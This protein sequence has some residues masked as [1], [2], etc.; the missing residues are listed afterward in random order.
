MRSR[1]RRKDRTMKDLGEIEA[2]LGRMAVG[3]LGLS[4]EDGPYVVPVN[5]VFDEGY[6]YFHSGHKGRKVEALRANP[7]VCFLVDEPGPQVTWDKGCGITQIYESVM[8]FGKAEFIEEI[9]ERRRILEML[10]NKYVPGGN[11]VPIPDGTVENMAVVRIHIEWMTGK[12]NRISSLHRKISN[13]F[14]SA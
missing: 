5:Y 14:L 7:R 4:T 10:I 3:R 6:V 8:C 2:L 1:P 12:A 13:S 11:H 9:A